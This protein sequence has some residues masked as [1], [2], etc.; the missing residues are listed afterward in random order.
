MDVGIILDS[1]RTVGR[2]N[3]EILKRA[4]A[5]FTDYFHVSKEGTH[6]GFIHYNENASLD[7]DFAD[8]SLYNSGAL[9]EKIMDIKYDPGLTRT[10]KALRLADERLFTDRGGV[11]KDVP[12]FLIVITDG[13]TSEG[14][15]PYIN[16]TA[17]LKVA[18]SCCNSFS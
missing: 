1:S 11:R 14:S 5:K 3:F 7:F 2:Y 15:L 6:F 4:L 10:D 17:P 13:K 8:S 16:F 18:L 9:K 12:K